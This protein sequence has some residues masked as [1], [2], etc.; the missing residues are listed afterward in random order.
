MQGR[1]AVGVL[2]AGLALAGSASACSSLDSGGEPPGDERN[3]AIPGREPRPA[4]DRD[5]EGQQALVYDR[6]YRICSVFTVREI[7]RDMGV[8]A[9]PQIAARAH[10]REL[11]GTQVRRAA[12]EGCIDAFQGR[13]PGV[14]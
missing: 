11:Y 6:S 12:Y 4:R 5:W 10:A 3:A 13:P 14:Q 2:V 8:A 9:K 7:A 1:R